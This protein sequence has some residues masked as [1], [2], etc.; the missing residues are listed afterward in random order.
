[1]VAATDTRGPDALHVE[2]KFNHDHS[3]EARVASLRPSLAPLQL[4]EINKIATKYQKEGD[5][6]S[7]Y[8]AYSILFEKARYVVA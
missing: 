1:M 6:V 4:L 3:I 7:A 8:A 5:C 2:V